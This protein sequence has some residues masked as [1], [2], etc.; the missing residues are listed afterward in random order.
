LRRRRSWKEERQDRIDFG[1]ESGAAAVYDSSIDALSFPTGY[2]QKDL[3]RAVLHEL[4]HAL[5]MARA[6]IRPALIHGLPGPIQRHLAFYV[7]HS[8]EETLR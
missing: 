2:R 5:T 6:Q 3:R 8:P 1:P 7:A 4:G